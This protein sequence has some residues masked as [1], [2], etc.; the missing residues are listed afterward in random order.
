MRSEKMYK[1]RFRAWKWSKYLPKDTASWMMNKTKER[2]PRRT[3]F[4]YGNQTWTEERVKR[5]Y[6]RKNV[7]ETQLDQALGESRDSLASS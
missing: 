2:Q 1:E 6:D 3:E 5:T 4:Q 7:D